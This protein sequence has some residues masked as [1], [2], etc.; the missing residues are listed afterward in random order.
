MIGYLVTGLQYIFETGWFLI[1][2]AFQFF[3]GW[4]F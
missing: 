2:N 3:F 1:T 4:L